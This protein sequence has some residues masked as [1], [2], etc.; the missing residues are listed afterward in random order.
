M[1]QQIRRPRSPAQK[2]VHPLVCRTGHTVFVI[3]W[4]NPDARACETKASVL[5]GSEG[6]IAAVADVEKATGERVLIASDIVSVERCS[7]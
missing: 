1:D 3:S 2:F 5:H 7:H 4:I 6:P